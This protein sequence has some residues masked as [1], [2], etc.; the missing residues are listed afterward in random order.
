MLDLRTALRARPGNLLA[1]IETL[2]DD[3]EQLKRA[4]FVPDITVLNG[5]VEGAFQLA[6]IADNTATTIFSITTAD[7]DGSNDG[8]VYACF[9]QAVI[10][11]PGGSGDTISAVKSFTAHFG[12]VMANGGTGVLTA[13]SEISE[14]A[15]ATTNSLS[16]DISTVTMTAVE[17]GE[18]QVDVKL[19]I[20]LTGSLATTAAVNLHVRM[21]YFGFLS[22]PGLV[23]G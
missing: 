23:A 11:H 21:V 16:R 1:Q 13:V 5:V 4:V 10:G 8:G 19:Q 7:E 9:V 14:S 2:Q 3:L 12:R 6:G 18:Y 20:D 17:N 22:P 15:S